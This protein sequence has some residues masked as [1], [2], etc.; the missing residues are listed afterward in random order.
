MLD[1][2][3][4]ILCQ[5]AT[6][7]P[8]TGVNAYRIFTL[9][10]AWR[11]PISACVVMGCFVT[12]KPLFYQVGLRRADAPDNDQDTL[13]IS[14]RDILLS[15]YTQRAPVAVLVPVQ[16]PVLPVGDYCIFLH[17]RHLVPKPAGQVEPSYSAWQESDRGN[18]YIRVS[19][20]GFDAT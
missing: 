10:K 15:A 16:L 9:Q 8:D 1:I 20:I 11:E 19:E 13:V 7:L 14:R 4:V 2:Q 3:F 17:W 12:Q 18:Y 5:S 6:F